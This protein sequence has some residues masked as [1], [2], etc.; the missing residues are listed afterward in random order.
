MVDAL[1]HITSLLQLY[2]LQEYGEKRWVESDLESYQFFKARVVQSLPVAKVKEE[3]VDA[4]PTRK[5]VIKNLEPAEYSVDTKPEAAK[6]LSTPSKNS[7]APSKKSIA[8]LEPK[9]SVAPQSIFNWK[10]VLYKTSPSLKILDTIPV[11]ID[12]KVFILAEG[13]LTPLQSA[14]LQNIAIAIT[15]TL[16][17]AVVVKKAPTTDAKLI[18]GSDITFDLEKMVAFP[19]EK[20]ILWQKIFDRLCPPT[21]PSS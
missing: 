5:S 14:L 19:E 16:E 12:P 15:L 13:S 9:K 18:L 8:Q 1:Q 6:D 17:P 10:E 20:A 4:G 11:K 2:L 21:P 3:R 7:A